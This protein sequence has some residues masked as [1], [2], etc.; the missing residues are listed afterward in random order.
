MRVDKKR[1]T[2]GIAA[3]VAAIIALILSIVS[4]VLLLSASSQT[5]S[6]ESSSESSAA[7]TAN[8]QDEDSGDSRDDGGVNVSDSSINAS[9]IVEDVWIYNE[10]TA[11]YDVDCQCNTSVYGVLNAGHTY[12]VG[13][14]YG[15]EYLSSYPDLF[16]FPD[17]HLSVGDQ[18]F[19]QSGNR[20]TSND[21]WVVTKQVFD[22]CNF[23]DT[24]GS[25]QLAV[26]GDIHDNA[27]E[28]PAY[29]GGFTFLVEQHH[30]EEYG[31]ILY[32]T[33]S[34]Q[35]ADWNA[36]E[37]SSCLLGIKVRVFV[38]ERTA[39]RVLTDGYDI[40]TSDTVKDLQASIGHLSRMLILQQFSTEQRVRSEGQSGLTNVRGHYDGDAAFDDGTYT[41]GQT[42]SIHDHAD[43]ILVVG[44]GEIQG[45][46]NG[47]E[48]RTRHND[49]NLNMASRTSD[50]YN[51]VESIPLPEVPPEVLQHGKNVSA[52]VDEMIE[53]FRAFKTQNASHRNYALYFKPI[54]CYLEGTWIMD[55]ELLDEPFDSDRH[56]IDAKSWQQLHD[57]IRWMSNSGRK[58]VLENLAHLPSSI[59]NLLNDTYPIISNW[60][61]RILCHPLQNDVATS[62]L[63]IEDDLS[64]QLMGSP[65][66]RQE[67]VYSRRARFKLN[68][69]IDVD[70]LADDRWIAGRKRWNYLDYL[71]EQIPG[72]NNYGANLTDAFPDGSEEAIHY[73]TDEV[74]NS[75]YYSRF[76]GL[77]ANDAM[78]SSKHR[79]G[80]ADRYLFAAKNTQSK[81]SPIA[82]DY[83]MTDEN[84][85]DVLVPTVSR[86]SYAIPLEMIYTTPLSTWN[87]YNISFVEREVFDYTR[88][89]AC[90]DETTAFDGW[91]IDAAYFT[92]AEMFEGFADS[93]SADTASANVCSRL[94]D[95]DSLVQIAASGHWVTFPDI[96]GGV[97]P[98]RQR[99]PIFPIHNAGSAAFKEVKALQAVSL[100][101]D[102]DDPVS[103]PDG[104]FGDSRDLKYG[105][106]LNLEGG[107]HQHVCYVDGWRVAYYWLLDATTNEW[108]TS[109]DCF[110]EAECDTREGHQH[111]VRV[112]REYAVDG[113]TWIYHLRDCRYGTRS[114]SDLWPYPMGWTT[115]N[116]NGEAIC[117]ID[118]HNTLDR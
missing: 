68:T 87:P 102:Y 76:Y 28:D 113:E 57:K 93:S 21:V 19:F 75:G 39:V 64:V 25:K 95:A 58:D 12:K 6:V 104:F 52:Q 49:Y 30:L 77:M 43:N 13:G 47:V 46:L 105:F 59:R 11:Y 3:L 2:L 22:S 10:T 63:M 50:E 61:Y 8:E 62:R 31:N 100:P 112:W 72:K 106:E 67:L 109:P 90:T 73:M 86:W 117:A 37:Q 29:P 60:E 34:R 107:G 20:W 85:K 110:I 23:T 69:H 99:Y 91:T 18:L 27:A 115:F 101:E 92:P 55:D 80:W 41:N 45:V 53:W 40:S 33:S 116:V 7:V 103:N 71:M 44:I 36:N 4:M 78:G 32:F 1:Y 94:A 66:T 24:S 114:D 65:E 96:A 118:L 111:F 48:F 70:D 82:F 5:N 81:V 9:V 17:I 88:S 89:G 108:C 35:W 42:A 15:W 16:P 74:L 84:G 26:N 14:Y 83:E 56:H 54:L 97:G 51:A 79:R 98:V 38:E